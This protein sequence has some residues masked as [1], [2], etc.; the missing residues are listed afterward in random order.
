MLLALAFLAFV[1]MVLEA[2]R[3]VHHDRRLRA[4]GATEPAGDVYRLMQVAYPA[5]FLAMI[6]EAWLRGSGT[7]AA[8][9]MGLVT[10][11][12]AKG[13]KYWAIATLGTRWTFRVLVPPGSLRIVAGPYRWLRHPN[14]VAVVGE[15]VGFALTAQAPFAGV[16]A[17]AGFS[18]LILARIRIEERALTPRDGMGSEGTKAT[19]PESVG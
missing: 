4:A 10:F 11:S 16:T 13:L 7:G 6:G 15:L 12:A 9:T 8:F 1:P 5:C 3:A 18:T 17:V 19:E 14:Y 2:R